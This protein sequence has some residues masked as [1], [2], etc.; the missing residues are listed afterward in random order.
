MAGRTS[1]PDVD[2]PPTTPGTFDKD[3]DLITG[4]E[5]RQDALPIRPRSMAPMPHPQGRKASNVRVLLGVVFF[6]S[7]IVLLFSI[8]ESNGLLS[9]FAGIGAGL[10]LFLLLRPNRRDIRE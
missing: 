5:T 3:F 8:M 1:A 7:S 9:T 6:I 2:R 4:F 10:S